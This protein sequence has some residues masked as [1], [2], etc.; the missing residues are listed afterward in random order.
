MLGASATKLDPEVS[1]QSFLNFAF[2]HY[3]NHNQDVINV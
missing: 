3:H 1:E 2:I